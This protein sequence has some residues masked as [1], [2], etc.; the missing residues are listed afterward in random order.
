[1]EGTINTNVNNEDE[2]FYEKM[3]RIQAKF[4]EQNEL[5]SILEKSKNDYF[6]QVE[7][8]LPEEPKE[9]EEYFSI[10]VKEKNGED[11]Y[12]RRFRP[13]D[14]IEDVN[15]DYWID[16]VFRMATALCKIAVG[17]IRTRYTQSNALWTQDGAQI[18]DEGNTELTELRN[19]LQENAMLIY[20]YD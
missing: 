14:S 12:I 8:K 10:R 3:Q 20:P 5:N 16:I 13:T 7:K 18:L 6:K 19:S 11:G 9:D 4:F 1:M 17:R 2:D 15:S